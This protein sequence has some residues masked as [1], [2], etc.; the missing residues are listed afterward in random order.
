MVS[1]TVANLDKLVAVLCEGVS[2]F[3]AGVFH[4]SCSDWLAPQAGL[5]SLRDNLMQ[6]SFS[7]Y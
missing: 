5:G 4:T 1:F 3:P 2:D 6:T 7:P